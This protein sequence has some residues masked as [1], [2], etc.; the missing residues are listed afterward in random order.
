VLTEVVL[1]NS[2]SAVLLISHGS[3]DPRPQIEMARLAELVAQRLQKCRGVGTDCPP[4]VEAAVLELAQPLHQQ[5][6]QFAERA[7]ALGCRRLHGVPIFLLPG[8]HVM[9]DIPAEVAIAQQTLG[10]AIALEICPYLGSHVNLRE[11][12]LDLAPTITPQFGR[13]LLGHGSRRAGGNQPMEMLAVQLNALPA[14]WSVTP[15]L[16]EQVH[17]LVSQGYT[18]I[19]ILPYFL[20]AGGITDAIAQSLVG[21]KQQLPDV[22]LRW[23]PPM[24]AT[25]KLASLVIEAIADSNEAFNTVRET[26]KT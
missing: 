26:A 9:E 4:L 23:T 24:G 5:I 1:S 14:Y 17:L 18:H 19:D 10:D 15:S 8:V 25:A 2:H 12:W 7:I 16:T 22:C 3:R 6:Q 20:F 13:I 21:L 11:V